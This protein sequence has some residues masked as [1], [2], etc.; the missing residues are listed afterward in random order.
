M[1]Y[2]RIWACA[3]M[4]LAALFTSNARAQEQTLFVDGNQVAPAP[5]VRGS[6]TIVASANQLPQL[7]PDEPIARRSERPASLMAPGDVLPLATGGPA[8]L[9]ALSASG[10]G[11]CL[12]PELRCCGPDYC[13]CNSR[14]Y[15]G[16]DPRDDDFVHDLYKPVTA[17]HWYQ[18]AFRMVVRK[19]HIASAIAK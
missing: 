10:S 13:G 6:E 2:S 11:C 5:W 9:P 19:K 1:T 7:R 15:Y 8:V 14:I 12:R 4:M 17:S 3:S 16:T 18:H